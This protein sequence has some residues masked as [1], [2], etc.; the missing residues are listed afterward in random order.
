MQQRRAEPVEQR[1]FQRACY[2][3]NVSMIDE[4]LGRIMDALGARGLLDDTVIVF[5]SDHGDSLGDH[6]HSQKWNMYEETVR[7]PAICWMGPGARAGIAAREGIAA[8]AASLPSDARARVAGLV[9]LFDLGPT[10]LELAG[11]SPPADMEAVSLFPIVASRLIGPTRDAPRERRPSGA[12]DPR[13]TGGPDASSSRLIER[14]DEAVSVSDAT[15]D[16]PSSR[17]AFVNADGTRRYV[18]AEHGRDNILAETDVM[19]MVRDDRWKLVTFSG[20]SGGQLFD[21]H[22]DPDERVNLWDDPETAAERR[23]LT[24]VLHEWYRESVYLTRARR[25]R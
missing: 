18:F 25:R 5:A 21:L 22:R 12:A 17:P 9:S 3:A 19:T 15:W 23:R 2:L 11:I 4:Q 8:P 16:V 14:A 10:V 7:V 13:A 24:D 20:A 1:R 6:G